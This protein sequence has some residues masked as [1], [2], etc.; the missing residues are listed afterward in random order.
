MLEI[1]NL[2]RNPLG[3]VEGE[4]LEMYLIVAFIVIFS[5]RLNC[6]EQM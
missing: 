1:S 2:E 3:V 6:P 4:G 5:S